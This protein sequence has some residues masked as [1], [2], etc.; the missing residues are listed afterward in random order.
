MGN[1]IMFYLTEMRKKITM[2]P[3]QIGPFIKSFLYL[4][5]C[6]QIEE[7]C[8]ETIGC[9]IAVHSIHNIGKGLVQYETGSV[10]FDVCFTS[11]VFKP[12]N[13]DVIDV[14]VQNILETYVIASAGP[15][16]VFINKNNLGKDLFDFINI[17]GFA[18][19]ISKEAKIRITSGTELRVRILGSRR[20]KADCKENY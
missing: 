4:K 13:N 1:A 11:V 10:V 14:V 17:N 20:T 9:V 2:T 15:T 6:Q 7:T 8:V 12:K 3:D 18:C 16:K 19:F 5:I